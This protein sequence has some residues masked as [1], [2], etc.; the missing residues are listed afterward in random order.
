MHLSIRIDNL[1]PHKIILWK[2]LCLQRVIGKI[3]LLE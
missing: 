3:F 2:T 1:E